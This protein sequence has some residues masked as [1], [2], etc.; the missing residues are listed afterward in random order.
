MTALVRSK[1]DWQPIGI[2]LT[3]GIVGL[4]LWTALIHLSLG[5]LLFTMNAIG[6]A[7]L[8]AAQVVP[9]ELAARYRW[10]PRFAL[11]GFTAATIAGWLL[12]GARFSLGYLATGIEVVMLVL[13]AIAIVRENGSPA[14]MIRRAR[15]GASQIRG[16]ILARAA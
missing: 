1:T 12:F 5:G 13:L 11:A 9:G 7:V 4:S 6:F 3:I 2:V 15:A 14:T 10:I 8:A 16:Q